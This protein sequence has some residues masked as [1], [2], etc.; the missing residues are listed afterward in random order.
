M[1]S[2]R[3]PT[4]PPV[5]RA[6]T[7][8]GLGPIFLIVFLDLIGFSLVL[9][10]LAE[11]ARATFHTSSLTGTLLASIYS[12]MQF[13]FVPVWGR[14]SDRIGRRP[15][16]VWSVAATAL[17]MFGLGVGLVFAKHVAWLFVIRAFS[18]IATAN[19]GTASAYIADVTKPEDRARGMG[20]IGMA[21]GL[22]FILG[23]G[24]GGWLATYEILGRTGAVPCFAAGALS[25]VNL[26]WAF[27]GLR[28]SLPPERRAPATP[29][30]GP[31]R[32]QGRSLAPLNVEAA[33]AALGRPGVA[34]AIL[35]NFMLVLSFTVL[36]QTF[37]F[38]NKDVFGMNAAQTGA[39]L[40]F[41]G[42]VGAGAQGGLVRPLAKRVDES[43][44][45]RGG[46]FLQ[47]VAFAGFTAAPSLGRWMLYVAGATIAVGNG[48]TQPSIAAYVSKRADPREQGGTLGTNQSF[49]SLARTFGPAVGG[50]L[51]GTF[52]PRAPYAY[53]ALGM[54]LALVV[55]FG[56][57]PTSMTVPG[58][59]GT[60]PAKST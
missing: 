11:E 17:G 2:T 24:I 34:Q 60:T 6:S 48:L 20:L 31:Y 56:I 53:G 12:L 47:A 18:G 36:D 40:A 4:V 46:T 16:L 15:V 39:V 52:G 23:P 14:V 13:L 7:P 59:D 49:S 51:Y 10:F 58:P 45:I 30:A 22:G 9:P 35:V 27:V 50:W 38:Y 21:F 41:I 37:R 43:S 3:G 55:A 19:L 32:S 29:A 5:E 26:G 25:V 44:L 8:P 1:R 42:V 33:R 57:R 54:T 28:E